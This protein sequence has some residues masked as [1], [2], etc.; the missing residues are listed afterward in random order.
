MG[1]VSDIIGGVFGGTRNRDIEANKANRRRI[2]W[3]VK[4][5]QR[6]GIHPLFALGVNPANTQTYGDSREQL[7]EGIGGGIEAYLAKDDQAEAKAQA[8]RMADA[9]IKVLESEAQRND[10]VTQSTQASILERAAQLSNQLRTP[11]TIYPRGQ[12]DPPGVPG[13]AP[14]Q[15]E[16][17]RTPVGVLRADKQYPDA[18]EAERRYGDIAQE[19]FGLSNLIV[20]LFRS[21]QRVGPPWSSGQVESGWKR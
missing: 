1:W 16:L 17:F 2:R 3:L 10:A 21:A 15:E 11:P 5:A 4:D 9:Q 19:V 13:R 6:A 12:T 8:Q 14:H 20:D 7:A 18:E